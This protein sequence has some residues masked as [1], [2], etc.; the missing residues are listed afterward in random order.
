MLQFLKTWRKFVVVPALL[1][2]AS[3]IWI[4]NSREE[5]DRNFV[6]RTVVTLTAP[7]QSA[8]SWTIG[9]IK[10]VWYGYFYFVGLRDAQESLI[11]E[12][13]TLRGELAETWETRAENERLRKLLDFEKETPGKLVAASVIGSDSASFAKSLRINRGSR[14]GLARNMAVVT[15][16]GVLGRIT[17]VSPFYSDV[18]LITDG[19]SA[20]AVR[21]QRTRA[22]G[23][24]EGLGQGLCHLKYVSRAEDVQQGD[25]V[26]TS[27]LG[28]IFPRGLVVGTVISV[29]KQEFGVLQDVQ[30][31]PAADFSRLPEEVLVFVSPPQAPEPPETVG[32][33]GT[34]HPS[35]AGALPPVP[36]PTP[37]SHH[38]PD[39]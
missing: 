18:Q 8:V 1:L 24:L 29:D 7:F 33:A 9:G 37:A 35:G 17:E 20:V 19:R 28:G 3:L 31:Q 12:N 34:H 6:D 2:F 10:R 23:I 38:G 15:A 11:K 26:V 39:E 27:G 13:D 25:V 30:V 36:T 4:S 32:V 5:K 21:V 22:Q 14:H 16:S